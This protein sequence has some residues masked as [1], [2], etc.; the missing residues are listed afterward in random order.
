MIEPDPI[1]AAETPDPS[2]YRFP[3]AFTATHEPTSE[4]PDDGAS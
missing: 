4:E 2:L 3:F 1:P